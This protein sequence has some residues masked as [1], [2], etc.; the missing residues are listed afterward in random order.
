M[1]AVLPWVAFAI[2]LAA[3]VVA[4]TSFLVLRRGRARRP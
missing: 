4:V 2:S 3:L 1:E